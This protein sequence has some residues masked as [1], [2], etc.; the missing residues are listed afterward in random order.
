MPTVAFSTFLKT[1]SLG[2]A[3]KNAHFAKYQQKGGYDFYWRLKSACEQLCNG[4]SV[5]EAFE[6]VEAIS[7][8]T[9]RQHNVLGFTSVR[10]WTKKNGASFF[11][12]PAG[13]LKSAS[14]RLKVKLEPELGVV[15]G[16]KRMVVALWNSKDVALKPPIA[17]VGV[18]VLRSNLAVGDYSN[19]T[20]HVLNTRNNKLFDV[21]S[22]PKNANTILKADLAAIDN[23]LEDLALT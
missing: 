8:P 18:H 6:V 16:G 20:F 4:A 7:S 5:E 15:V 17:G 9:E 10:D 11:V 22:I 3:Q 23:L 1:L 2:T 12:P 21:S 14:G 19:C 13:S